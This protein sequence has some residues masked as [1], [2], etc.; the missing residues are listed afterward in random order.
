MKIGLLM[1]LKENLKALNLPNM[2]SNIEGLVRQAK[3]TGIG[4]DEFLLNLTVS[5]LQARS[6]T[7]FIFFQPQ[8][9]FFVNSYSFFKSGLFHKCP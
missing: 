5:E 9:I 6:P 1:E 4:Y 2:V 8:Q 7:V 3:E